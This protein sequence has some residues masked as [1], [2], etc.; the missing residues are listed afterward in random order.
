[1]KKF[2][3]KLY[4]FL[5][6]ILFCSCLPNETANSKNTNSSDSTSINLKTDSSISSII[7]SSF[8]QQLYVNSIKD[9]IKG[10]NTQYAI[11]L[12]QLYFINRRNGQ[13]DDFPL[14]KLPNEI[15]GVKIFLI[16]QDESEKNKHNYSN[17]SLC[18]NMIGD[19]SEK[20]A[21]F[22]FITFFK[23]FKHQFDMY[24]NYDIEDTLISIKPTSMRIEELVYSNT[25]KAIH[26]TIFKDGKLVGNRPVD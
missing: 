4:S 5:L 9:Y 19:L 24:L 22:V 26:Y 23:E 21:E 15:D 7:D 18:I 25:G 3:Y 11:S 13:P 1:M 14:I 6:G 12:E 17:L 8:V 2:S 16:S 20:N 10:V